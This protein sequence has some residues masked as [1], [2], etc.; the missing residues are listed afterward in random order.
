[1]RASLVESDIAGHFVPQIERGGLT[2]GTEPYKTVFAVIFE[3]ASAY[4]NVGLSLGVPFNNTSLAS[5]FNTLSKLV[6]C[7]L[8]L[9]GRTRGLPVAQDRAVMTP[10]QLKRI[11]DPP[12]HES[13]DRGKR[14]AKEADAQADS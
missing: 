6:L 14:A 8:M 10:E 3:A 4:S 5:S 12:E 9:R 13:G 7:A 1:M 2:D 11:G